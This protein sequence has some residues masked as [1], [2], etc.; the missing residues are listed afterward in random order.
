MAK[1]TTLT[2]EQRKLRARLAAYTLHSKTDARETTKA[3]RSAFIDSFDR[4]VDPNG[5]L[6]PEERA[7]RAKAALRAH[8]TSL[9][10]KSSRA[11]SKM[12]Q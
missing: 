10:L 4:E 5:V 6:S 1:S 3:A 2:P 8:M 7:R 11:R 12:S 9:A